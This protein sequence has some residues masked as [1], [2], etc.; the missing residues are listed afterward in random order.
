MILINLLALPLLAVLIVTRPADQPAA[1][2]SPPASMVARLAPALVEDPNLAVRNDLIARIEFEELGLTLEEIVAEEGGRRGLLK[3]HAS[4]DPMPYGVGDV[5]GGFRVASIDAES[6]TFERHGI[7]FWL[8]PPYDDGDAAAVET[9]EAPDPEPAAP[10]E[11]VTRLVEAAEASPTSTARLTPRMN[12]KDRTANYHNHTLVEDGSRTA[13][14]LPSRPS[15]P[16][17]IAPMEGRLTSR[18]GYRRHPMG[19]QRRFHH[20]V[21][22]AAPHGT[23][24]VA[25]ASGR[26]T[27]STY[28]S[29]LGNYIRISHA[30][31]YETVYAHLSRRQVQR[32]Q[33]VS[34]GQQIGREGSTGR[35]T[36]PH[37]HFEIRRNGSTLN[38][39]TF[40]NF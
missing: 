32:G 16:R 5:V 25:A 38:P 21:D 26:V 1:A 4:P 20:G 28:N 17:F 14:V 39:E 12:L 23:P 24:V 7:K 19:G 22:I 6:V 29:L 36:G 11:E 2:A 34:Q 15:G 8:L 35:S 31:G 10:V 3:H 18:Y 13:S 9:A 37:L 30:D 27:R 40:L 33:R